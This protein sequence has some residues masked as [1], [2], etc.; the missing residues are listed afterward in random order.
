M[1]VGPTLLQRENVARVHFK[2]DKL[3]S[4][5]Y[6]RGRQQSSV[7]ASTAAL[8]AVGCIAETPEEAEEI[9]QPAPPGDAISQAKFD[10][11]V[12]EARL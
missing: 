3:T 2:A 4:V 7:L 12:V 8:S 5:W 6:K 10:R 9:V 11:A 1:E